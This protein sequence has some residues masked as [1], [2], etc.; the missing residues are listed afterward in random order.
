MS[1][2]VC[3]LNMA[4]RRLYPL[5]RVKSSGS[6]VAAVSRIPG[7]IEF[8]RDDPRESYIVNE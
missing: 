8:G 4:A 7:Q 1:I 5:R 2:S 6:Q 3:R